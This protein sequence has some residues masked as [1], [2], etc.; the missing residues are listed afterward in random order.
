MNH[1]GLT[2]KNPAAT[3][4]PLDGQL[5]D[6]RFLQV[7]RGLHFLICSAPIGQERLLKVQ[8]RAHSCSLEL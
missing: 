1:P 2:V 4:F 6:G 3:L 7:G 5:F 8:S